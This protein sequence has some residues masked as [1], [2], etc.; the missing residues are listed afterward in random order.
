MSLN[1]NYVFPIMVSITSILLNS[2]NSTYI[3]INLLISNDFEKINI[4]KIISLKK[5]KFYTHFKFHKVGNKFKNWK[6]GRNIPVPAFYRSILGEIIYDTNKII[7][8][9]GD[10]LAYKDLTDMY[11][12]NMDNLYFKGIREV[13]AS[14]EKYIDKSSYICD[15][16]MLINI[17]LIRK[18]RVFYKFQNYYYNYYEQGIFYGD[19]HIIND[20]FRNKIGYLPPKYG[21]FFINKKKIQLYKQLNPLIYT[22]KE[23]LESVYNPVLRH[24][25][26]INMNNEKVKK[27]WKIDYYM[28]IKSE[29]N[30]YAK[31]TG[32]YSSIC[33]FYKKVC[34]NLSKNKNNKI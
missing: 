4:Y 19:Q 20:L 31:K 16:V 22:E 1:N 9:D 26:G 8:L 25:C 5:L 14:Y 11:N 10:T 27:P 17:E 32:Y 3:H 23:L 18:E 30:Y 33:S 13:P 24:I 21:M 7:Y 2:K 28:K 34:L 29:W 15:G 12:I 6:H